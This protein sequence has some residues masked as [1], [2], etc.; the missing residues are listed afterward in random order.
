MRT[1][2]W[3]ILVLLIFGI[4][5]I[6]MK[7]CSTA[8]RMV[9]NGVETAYQ[10][11]KPEELLRKY[12]WFK[13]AHAQLEAKQSNIASYNLRFQ[14]LKES[15]GKDSNNRTQWSRDD[16]ESYNIWKS[17]V[18]GVTAS[19]NDLA[20]Q[21]NSEMAKFNWRFCNTGTLPQGATEPLPREYVPYK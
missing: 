14:D 19:Y 18:S 8:T 5:S 13:D 7:T 15:Y 16:K 3:F 2:A 9:N 11:F 12:E 1:F 21:Y 4:I 20:A 10:E 17:E 6:T